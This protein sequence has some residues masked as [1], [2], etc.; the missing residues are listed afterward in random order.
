MTRVDGRNLGQHFQRRVHGQRRDVQGLRSQ[1]V[2]SAPSDGDRYAQNDVQ[3]QP[4]PAA[5]ESHSPA[6]TSAQ[7]GRD[8]NGVISGRQVGQILIG[9]IV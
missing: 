6:R 2:P 5:D 9:G 1:V 4:A 7:R 8:R 3:E